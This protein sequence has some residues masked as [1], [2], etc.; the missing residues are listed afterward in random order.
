LPTMKRH[1]TASAND[2]KRKWI[3]VFSGS[4]NTTNYVGCDPGDIVGSTSGF[5]L[6]TFITRGSTLWILAVAHSSRKPEYGIRRSKNT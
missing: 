6:S 4:L 3:D 2:S 1:A 5:S